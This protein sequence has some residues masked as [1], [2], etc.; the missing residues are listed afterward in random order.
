METKPNRLGSI[1]KTKREGRG[2]SFREAAKLTGIS[3]PNLWVLE[4]GKNTNPTTATLAA[5][6]AAYGVSASTLL[7]AAMEDNA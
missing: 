6:S 3:T 1:L 2:L 4:S 7:K 5:L